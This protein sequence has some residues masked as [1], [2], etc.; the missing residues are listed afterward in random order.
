[1]DGDGH[2]EVEQ[3]R[4]PSCK[5]DGNRHHGERPL[6]P[7]R[8]WGAAR[9]AEPPSH[10]R[11]EHEG[12]EGPEGDEQ[13]KQ[14]EDDDQYELQSLRRRRPHACGGHEPISVMCADVISAAQTSTAGRGVYA[15]SQLRHARTCK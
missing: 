13:G 10:S 3:P 2:I 4:E 5:L 14:D 1:M 11:Y 15:D 8:A 6:E 12:D 7:A 9:V